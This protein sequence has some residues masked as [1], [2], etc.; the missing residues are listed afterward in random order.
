M[1]SDTSRP[2][3][4]DPDRLLARWRALLAEQP[5]THLPQAAATL[6]VSEGA[7]LATRVGSGAVCLQP[8]LAALLDGIGQWRKLFVVTPSR[9]GVTIAILEVPGCR[10]R[11]E[12]RIELL[13]KQ[14]RIVIDAARIRHC[15]LFEDRDVHG[16][17]LSLC[18]FDAQGIAL[19]KLFLRSRRGQELAV[20][21]LMA[22]TLPEQSRVFAGTQ[23]PD[24]GT[25][26]L[27]A[28]GGEAA[29]SGMKADARA[30]RLAHAALAATCHLAAVEL[31]MTGDALDALYRGPL[32]SFSETPGA[33]HLSAAGCK[34]HLRPSA[35]HAV[36]PL[37]HEDGRHGLRIE[38]ANGSLSI[39]PAAQAESHR[40]AALI[41]EA[42]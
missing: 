18:W 15:Y 6:G 23:S 17:S 28:T 39:L 31:R 21:R 29:S 9:L 25:H 12:D 26:S 2:S 22:Q 7:L 32:T 38:T 10:E 20:P 4:D 27:G 5:H 30:G 34:A 19:G 13:G 16:H 35:A 24:A 11:E 40:L 37:Q 14:H 8:R 41:E 1:R 33:L 36:L 42:P 3:A